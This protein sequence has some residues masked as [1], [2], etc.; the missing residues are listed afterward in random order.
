MIT[1]GNNPLYL[2]ARYNE[3]MWLF[4]WIYPK[5]CVGCGVRGGYICV[6]CMRTVKA[7]GGSLRYQGVVRELIKEIK[8]RGSFDMV[9]EL[10]DRWITICGHTV[11]KSVDCKYGKSRV[12]TA[13]PMYPPKQKRRGFNQAELVARELAKRWR[14]PYVELLVRTRETRPM[15]GLKRCERSANVA[16]AFGVKAALRDPNRSV[17]LVDDV[18]TS[19]ATLGECCRVLKSS[20]ARRVSL[21]AIAR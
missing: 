17:I 13:V 6:K 21:V 15:Y 18:L 8:Y 10:V 4:D 9:A 12:V 7:C 16:G 20:G 2:N 19:G 1:R 14:Y 11:A 5:K 3:T